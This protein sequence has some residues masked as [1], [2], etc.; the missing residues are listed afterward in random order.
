MQTGAF[1]K[2]RDDVDFPIMQYE[3]LPLTR[4]LVNNKLIPVP[5]FQFWMDPSRPESRGGVTLRSNDP[6]VAPSTVFN[7]YESKQDMHDMIDGIRLAREIVSQPV[8]RKVVRGAWT[9]RSCRKSSPGTS[10]PPRS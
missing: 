8:W 3:F 1:L 7:H 10:T 2:T 4:R 6:T 9:H 5:G